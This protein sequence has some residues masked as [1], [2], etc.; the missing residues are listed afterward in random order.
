MRSSRLVDGERVYAL[1][2][3]DG[4]PAA[5]LK[6][7]PGIGGSR[8]AGAQVGVRGSRRYDETL[9]ADV[10]EVNDLE[11]LSAAP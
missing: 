7:A 10:I 9:R 6:L 11:P 4:F 5:Y 8:Y 3:A 1:I 2:G